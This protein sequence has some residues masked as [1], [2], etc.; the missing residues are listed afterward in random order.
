MEK[1]NPKTKPD[2]L[3]FGDIKS[4]FE[5]DQIDAD[6]AED[7]SDEDLLHRQKTQQLLQQND[8]TN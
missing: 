5:Q 7:L 2:K 1:Q 3:N 4:T 6:T 8:I